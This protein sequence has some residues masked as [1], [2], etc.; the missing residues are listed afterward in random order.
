MLDTLKILSAL[1]F[2]VMSRS[3]FTRKQ[4]RGEGHGT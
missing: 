4:A 2:T 1:A 3:G